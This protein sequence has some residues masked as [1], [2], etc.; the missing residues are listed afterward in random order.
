MLTIKAMTAS[1]PSGSPQPQAVA[2]VALDPELLQRVVSAV[3]QTG[4]SL[5]GACE[6]WVRA[7]LE[8]LEAQLAAAASSGRCSVRLGTATVGPVPLPMQQ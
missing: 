4:Q 2:S 5:E 8:Q 6:Q 7:G 3:A 1:P